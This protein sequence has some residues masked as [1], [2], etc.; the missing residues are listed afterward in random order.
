MRSHRVVMAF[1]YFGGMPWFQI[2][3]ALGDVPD[4]VVEFVNAEL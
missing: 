1:H 2:F 3:I 4:S